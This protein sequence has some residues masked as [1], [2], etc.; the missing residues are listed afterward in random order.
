[1]HMHTHTRTHTH[2]HTQAGTRRHT[3][4]QWR[5]KTISSCGQGRSKLR[6]HTVNQEQSGS[7]VMFWFIYI[8]IPLPWLSLV[9]TFSCP[10]KSTLPTALFGLGLHAVLFGDPLVSFCLFLLKGSTCLGLQIHW[11]FV[12]SSCRSDSMQGQKPFLTPPAQVLREALEQ[13]SEQAYLVFLG[14]LL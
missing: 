13:E 10:G 2:T 4:R 5:M 8:A 7:R 6:T 1:M 3:Y 14:Y 11:A 9:T 12:L